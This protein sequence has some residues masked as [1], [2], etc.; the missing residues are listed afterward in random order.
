M[1]KIFRGQLDIGGGLSGGGT[2]P[3]VGSTMKTSYQRNYNMMP[4]Y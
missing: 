4:L 2:S 3:N 1:D